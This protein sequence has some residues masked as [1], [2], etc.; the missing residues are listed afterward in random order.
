[1]DI[2]LQPLNDSNASFHFE[3][4]RLNSLFM[5][6]VRHPLVVVCAGA[7]YGKTSAVHDFLREY[8]AATVWIQL[9]ERDNVGQRLWENYTHTLMPINEPFA[10]AVHKLGFPDTDDKMNQYLTLTRKYLEA[11]RRIIVADDFHFIENPSVIRFVERAINN[12][13][14]GS[15]M[16]LIS[17]STPHI[18]TAG[19]IAKGWL[20][21][22]SESDLLF[23]ESELAQ[24]FRRQGFSLQPDNLREIMRDTE[25]WAFSI[26]LV[27]RSYQKAPGYVGYLRS[28]MRMNIFHL[29][30]KDIWDG[31]SGRLQ[32]FLIRL[33]LIDHLSVDLISLLAGGD[34]NL[35]AELN[36]QN[37]YV[38]RDGYIN[39]YL[40]HH[41]FL[42][43]LRRK[44]ELLPEEQKRE[45][46]AIAGDWCNRNGFKIDALAYY[47]KVGDYETIVSIFFELPAQIP[48][49]IA[50]YAA[51]F[52][53][54]IPPEAFDRVD[55]LA[56]MYIRTVMC[57]GLWQEALKLAEFY[58]AK[59]LKMPESDPL[60][61]HTLG[62]ISY[63]W[64]ILRTLMCTIDDR[65]D[66]DAYYA[67]FEECLSKFPVEV[68]QLA[69]HPAGP[70]INLVGAPG[71]GAPLEYIDAATRAEKY[72]S[73][74]LNGAMTGTGDLARGELL[75]YRDDIRGAEPFIVRALDQGRDS[76]QFEIVHRALLYTLRIAVLQGHYLKME[77]ALK[78]IEVQLNEN[79]YTIRFTTYDIALAWY[80]YILCL[81]EKIPDWLKDKFTPYG[82]ASFLENFGNQAKARYCYLAKNFLPLLAYVEEQKQREAILFGRVEMLAMEAC[83]H[84]KMKDK[85]LAI[86]ALHEAYKTA[87]PNDIFMPFIEL[88]KDMRTLTAS[89]LKESSDGASPV[90]GIPGTWLEVVN[91]KSALYAK[92][93]AHIIAEYRQANNMANGI[94]ISPRESEILSDLAHGLSRTEMAVSRNLSVNTV[95]MVINNLY[96]K[97][98]AENMADLIR[99][100]TERRMI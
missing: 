25:G 5:E 33:S 35:I 4:P 6:A 15:S 43:F 24:Y 74:C 58:E 94:A 62:G 86:A 41:L 32:T 66:F 52:F 9:S 39:A 65:Y 71:K 34:G 99:I 60:R 90:S 97:M 54:K 78:D 53:D 47:E 55:Y 63:C 20:F 42:E 68:G 69:N 44:Q 31:I 46:Y 72:V 37:A 73:H 45:T 13:P 19:L 92:R 10:R 76:R 61:N 95:K 82:H 80:Y 51:R 18:N 64:G 27:A 56:V 11:K 36:R 98:G 28:A 84:Y 40:I 38:R 87:S 8:Q 26:N 22:I 49:D 67:K 23:T 75:F 14:V 1:M 3:R 30:E 7:G 48:Y 50:R 17:R 79:E 85:T 12:M 89:A 81:P 93:R 2:A 77:R 59:Y 29:M 83:I 96:S 16:F 100:A 21:T 57:L 91:R 88:G 70:W